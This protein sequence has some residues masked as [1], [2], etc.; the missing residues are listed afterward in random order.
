[1]TKLSAPLRIKGS[2]LRRGRTPRSPVKVRTGHHPMEYT[3]VLD[4]R[5]RTEK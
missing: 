3:G 2:A 1:M 5:I 4:D